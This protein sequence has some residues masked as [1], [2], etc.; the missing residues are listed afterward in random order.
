MLYEVI[1]ELRSLWRDKVLLFL[2]LWVFTGGVYVA[3]SAMST[4]V[5]KAPIAIVDEDHSPLSERIVV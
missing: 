5:N 2:I 1:T 4:D 3:A